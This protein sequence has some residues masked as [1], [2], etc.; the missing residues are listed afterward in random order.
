MGVYRGYNDEWIAENIGNY[1]SWVK[2]FEDYYQIFHFGNYHNF[3]THLY[4][5][6]GYTKKY[7]EEENE[8]LKKVY[9]SNGARKTYEMY[10]KRFNKKRGYQGFLTHL[11]DLGLKVTQERWREACQDN[12]KRTNVPNGTIVQRGRGENWIKVAAGTD[13][14]IPLTHHLIGKIEK[15]KRI[16]HLNG[17][18]ADDRLDNLAVI[19][20]KTSAIL[21]GCD[22]WSENPE[23]T[24]TA[25][26][27]AELKQAYENMEVE[28]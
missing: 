27:W 7:T 16:V 8:W 25:I 10:Q 6:L 1:S 21:T 24:K 12:G 17:N 13:G 3:R 26:I 28:E 20:L 2:M 15:N 4:S 14:W 18:K 22:M 19:S 5:D 11:T 9:P 23:V